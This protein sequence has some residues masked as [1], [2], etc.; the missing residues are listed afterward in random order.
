MFGVSDGVSMPTPPSTSDCGK[1]GVM[2]DDAASPPE[3]TTLKELVRWLRG[4]AGEHVTDESLTESLAAGL[5][6]EAQATLEPLAP[7][8]DRDFFSEA[9]SRQHGEVAADWAQRTLRGL[10]MN[11]GEEQAALAASRG[12][13]RAAKLLGKAF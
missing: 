9:A 10:A 11:I 3:T 6:Y 13:H 2:V 4:A 8:G 7:D 1:M 12:A 5:Y